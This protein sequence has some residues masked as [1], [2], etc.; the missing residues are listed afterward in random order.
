[1]YA[2]PAPML[3]QQMMGYPLIPAPLGSVP[4]PMIP[5]PNRKVNNVFL[6]KI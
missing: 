2:I 6:I 5:A 3:Q 1:M 4:S